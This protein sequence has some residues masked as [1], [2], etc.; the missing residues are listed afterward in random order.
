MNQEHDTAKQ[1]I[2][3]LNDNLASMDAATVNKLAQAR[4][5]AVS[6]HALSTQSLT[7]LQQGGVLRL[8]GSYFHHP[9]FS[10]AL[11]CCLVLLTVLTVQQFS[12][13]S[14]EQDIEQSDGFLLASDLPPEAYV[15]RGFDQWL[16]K[17][18]F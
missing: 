17:T 18:S 12:A 6:A 1:I 4:Q 11:L 5:R 8:F 9:A 2:H 15:D 14:N 3:L 10:A 16:E 7:D 13:P